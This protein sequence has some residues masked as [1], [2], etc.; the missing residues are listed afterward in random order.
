MEYTFTPSPGTLRFTLAKVHPNERTND[1]HPAALHIAGAGRPLEPEA[2][3]E[4][5]ARLGHDFS[6][7]RVHHDGRAHDSAATMRALAYTAG[8]DIVFQ[9]GR[10]NP[11]TAEGKLTL[12]HELTYVIRQS[13]RTVDGTEA[14][15]GA[16]SAARVIASN[17][18]RRRTPSRR[19]GRRLGRPRAGSGIARTV[20]AGR[21]GSGQ[22]RALARCTPSPGREITP[23]S[24]RGR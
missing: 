20:R 24:K 4:M 9:R 17:V 19:S 18:R 15:G 23:V 14:P 22:T 11:G 5:A 10:D 16:G 12:A 1:A 21:P 6:R 2:R 7:V 13:E 3:A 8:S